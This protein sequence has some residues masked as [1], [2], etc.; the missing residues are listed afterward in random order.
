MEKVF[1]AI[2][3]FACLFSFLSCEKGD[4]P[5]LVDISGEWKLDSVGG[6]PTN[7]LFDDEAVDIFITFSSDAAFETFQRRKGG[8]IFIRYFGTWEMKGKTVSGK[9]SDGKP[10]RTEYQAALENEG[11]TLTLTS[12]NEVCV[13]VRAEVPDSVRE[14]AVD[15]T[16]TKSAA[17]FPVTPIL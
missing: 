17:G 3:C 11:E 1:Q 8:G 9:Y 4:E 7:G 2:L 5:A 12:G 13:Y 15:Y 14:K 16:E 10:W 6:I